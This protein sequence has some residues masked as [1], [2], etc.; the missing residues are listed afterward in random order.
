M[1]LKEKSTSVDALQELI[2][3]I[4]DCERKARISPGLCVGAFLLF[5]TPAGIEPTPCRPRGAGVASLSSRTTTAKKQK[6]L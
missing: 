4:V 5:V 6:R 1:E 2:S 3:T